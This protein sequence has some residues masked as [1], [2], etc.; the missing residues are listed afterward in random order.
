MSTALAARQP[1]PLLKMPSGGAVPTP[2]MVWPPRRCV[3]NFSS[4]SS[5]PPSR[6]EAA[7]AAAAAR[8]PRR[9]ARS[10]QTTRSLSSSRM[11]TARMTS[12][13]ASSRAR[14][15]VTR[16]LPSSSRPDAGPS[17]WPHCVR[18]NEATQTIRTP[19]LTRT[20]AWVTEPTKSM[21]VP[22]GGSMICPVPTV[23]RTVSS[24]RSCTMLEKASLSAAV[25][26][27]A[28]P[29]PWNAEG[30]ESGTSTVSMC[31]SSCSSNSPPSR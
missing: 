4:V 21:A 12:V 17:P 26:Q 11:A 5:K 31:P 14:A 10:P 8:S 7:A 6:S 22:L 20:P 19:E 9:S 30:S 2:S 25:G 24:V 29:P 18:L 28:V 13:C 16:R 1:R 27:K 3:S 23:S 15:A